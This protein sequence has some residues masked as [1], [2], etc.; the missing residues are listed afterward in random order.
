M[1]EKIVT[2]EDMRQAVGGDGG[3]RIP[4]WAGRLGV[5]GLYSSKSSLESPFSLLSDPRSLALIDKL[6]RENIQKQ[7]C[8]VMT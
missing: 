2:N 5:E 4:F 1:P 3:H 8:M 6:Q 7:L